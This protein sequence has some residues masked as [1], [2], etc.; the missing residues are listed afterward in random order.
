MA[1]AKIR[2]NR[3]RYSPL[4]IDL[5]G[6]SIRVPEIAEEHVRQASERSIAWAEEQDLDAELK[7]LAALPTD[8]S[9]TG[10]I[11]HLAALAV[12]GDVAKLQSYQTTFEAGDRLGFVPYI[13]RDFIDRAVALAG[14][15]AARS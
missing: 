2:M 1:R 8:A 10:P 11:L 6:L 13:K 7:A 14:E 15:Y 5:N 3:R 4:V 12:S 9:G